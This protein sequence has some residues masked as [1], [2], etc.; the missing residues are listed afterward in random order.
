MVAAA[1]GDSDRPDTMAAIYIMRLWAHCQE[2]KSDRFKIPAAG[3]AAQ[4]RFKGDPIR[5]EQALVDAGFLA[6]EG[7]EIQALGWAEKN[8]SL[9]ASWANGG[10]GGRPRKLNGNNPQVTHGLATG[11]PQVTHGLPMENPQL[12][13]GL[14]DKRREE[15]KDQEHVEDP[16]DLLLSAPAPAVADCPYLEIVDAYHEALPMLPQVRQHTDSR[17]QQV[18]RHWRSDPEKQ[19]VDWWRRFFAYASESDF[20]TGRAGRWHACCFDW[21]IKPANFVKVIE[22]NYENRGAA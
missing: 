19:S 5:F 8:A 11:N 15:K 12:T 18:R 22:G 10:K 4:C 14:T 1:L 2:R 17:R 3:L 16:S 6:R 9:I 20:L 21:L 13:H 7:D